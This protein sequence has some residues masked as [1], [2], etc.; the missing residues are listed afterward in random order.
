VP[1][2]WNEYTTA[3]RKAAL[4][5][6]ATAAAAAIEAVPPEPEAAAA[7]VK[8]KPLARRRRQAKTVAE[9]A[10]EPPTG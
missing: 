10:Q 9:V 6:K 1:G 2:H 3:L 8:G 4:A 7:P 5:R